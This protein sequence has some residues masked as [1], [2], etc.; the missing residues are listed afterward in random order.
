MTRERYAPRPSL[1]PASSPR[2]WLRRVKRSGAQ[3]D[4]TFDPQGA[5]L[6]IVV[7]R[8]R[9]ANGLTKEALEPLRQAYGF[10]LGRDPKSV[11]AAEAEYWFGQAYLATGDK[12]GH[13]MVAEAQRTLATFPAQVT[14]GACRSHASEVMTGSPSFHCQA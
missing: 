10:W 7:G 1:T 12:R 14:S 5:D 2:A 3:D 9:L 6:G 4:F 13:W 8:A 11:W